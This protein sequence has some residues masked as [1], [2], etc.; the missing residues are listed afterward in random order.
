VLGFLLVKD[1]FWDQNWQTGF[2]AVQLEKSGGGF[3]KNGDWFPISGTILI[4]AIAASMVGSLFSS[5][6]WN[7]VTFIAAE[8]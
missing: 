8:I 3:V 2:H 5:D 6:A 7:N 1:N 4:G